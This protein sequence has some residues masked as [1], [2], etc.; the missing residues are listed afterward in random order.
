[1]TALFSHL[2]AVIF[3]HI[4]SRPAAAAVE[5][6]EER[7]TVISQE[8]KAFDECSESVCQPQCIQGYFG[9]K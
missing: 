2:Q 7:L 1:M 6:R 5:F 4:T 3:K 9:F 8:V